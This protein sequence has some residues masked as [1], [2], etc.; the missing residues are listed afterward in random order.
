MDV[1][2]DRQQRLYVVDCPNGWAIWAPT[3]K[4]VREAVEEAKTL[5]PWRNACRRQG[6]ATD[7]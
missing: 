6:I 1:K 5:P 4:R 3:E 7:Q 2:L